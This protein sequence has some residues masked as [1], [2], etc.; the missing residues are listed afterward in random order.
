[1]STQPNPNRYVLE[2]VNDA[3]E[4][5]QRMQDA[6]ARALES[7]SGG[8]DSAATAANTAATSGG[9]SYTPTRPDD[10][11]GTAPSTVRAAL[12]RL[13]YHASIGAG[14]VPIVELP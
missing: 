12:D 2:R 6:T 4:W 5:G 14:A 11:A 3:P 7:V 9:T 10:W 1:M 8:A 13:A